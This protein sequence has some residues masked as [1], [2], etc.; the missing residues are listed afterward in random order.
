LE[1]DFTTGDN[2]YPKNRQQNLHILNKYSKTVVTKVTHSE[3]TSFAQKGGRGGRNRSSNGNGKG[4][5][6]STYDKKSSKDKECYKC[7]KKGH[8]SMHC[9][10][11]PSDDNDRSTASAASSVKKLKKDLKSI[12]KSFT[13]VN[14][15]L[16]Q[17]KEA[18]S[19]ISESK[20]EE[21]SVDQS[22]QFAHLDR[23]FEPRIAN[24]FKQAGSSIKLDLKEVS[25]IN[26]Q[27]TMDLFCNAALVSK[28]SKSRSSMRLKSNGGTMVVAQ[29]ATMEGYN[30][31]VWFST[32]VITNIIALRNLIDQYRITYDSND[33]M[34]FVHR[35]SESKP[36]IEF[37]MRKSGI[38]YYDPRKEQHLTFVNTVSENKTGFINRKIK[39]AEI[40]RNLY[41]TLSYPS[42]KDFK[43]VIRSNQI[44]DCPVMIQDIDVATK[45]WG[46]NIAALKGKT[47]RSNMHPVAR[48]YVKVPKHL[49]KLHKEVFLKTDMFFVNKIP[50][51]MILSRKICFTA[52]NHL[53][54]RTVP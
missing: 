26:S 15:H 53:A 23:K 10:K 43:W 22:L 42:M 40:V 47:T 3:G 44:K 38:H 8:P 4:Y 11:K 51:F 9:P 27:S 31:T 20:G 36:N 7:H 54:D 30:K 41:K 33:L 19:H 35:D 14:T 50:F 45:I 6:S 1:K 18:D 2:R 29:K 49:L 34:F 39:C 46:K 12:K 21:T 28:I 37:K 5:D 17:L 24:L 48:D 13:T 52:F 32:C 16:A 25:L